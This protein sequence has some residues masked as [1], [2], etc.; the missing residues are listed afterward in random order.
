MALK[1]SGNIV[2]DLYK[3]IKNSSI[4]TTVTPNIFK[5]FKPLNFTGEC[6]VINSLPITGGQL[7][8]GVINV[9]YFVPNLAITTVNPVDRSQPDSKRLDAGELIL[10]QFLEDIWEMNGYAFSLQQCTQM[11]EH[12]INSWY[13]NL[14]VN[15]MNG[16]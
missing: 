14:R 6:I 16:N 7:Q 13:V 10:A 1:T 2:T 3:L 5:K 15:Y 9:N 4:P 12:E 8:K 11:P